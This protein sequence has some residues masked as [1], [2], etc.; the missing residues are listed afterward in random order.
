MNYNEKSKEYFQQLFEGLSARAQAIL[1]Y[2]EMN[3]IESISPWLIGEADERECIRSCGEQTSQEF[4]IMVHQLKI[5][6]ANESDGTDAGKAIGEPVSSRIQTSNDVFRSKEAQMEFERLQDNLSLRAKNILVS[7]GGIEDIVPWIEGKY[8]DFLNCRNCGRKTSDELMEMM[9]KLRER[10]F[11]LEHES[12]SEK[13]QKRIE[14]LKENFKTKYEQ[15]VDPS[16]MD[17]LASKYMQL[18]YFPF[19]LALNS[20]KFSYENGDS[21]VLRLCSNIFDEKKKISYSDIAL[22]FAI[23]PE[24]VRR[25]RDSQF[26]ELQNIIMDLFRTGCLGDYK[27][28]IETADELKRIVSREGVP[29]NGNFIVWVVCQIDERY[30]LIGDVNNA[31][32]G[33][34][35]S[36]ETLSAVR[37]ELCDFFDFRN[38][39]E[40]VETRLQEN[41]FD[42]E[43]IELEQYVSH[44]YTGCTDNPIFDTIVKACRNILEMRRP[45]IMVNNQIVFP[46]NTMKP[47]SLLV[48]DLL[49]EFNRPM[50]VDEICKQLSTRFP[51]IK[52]TPSRIRNTLRQK[53]FVPVSRTSTYALAEWS[54]TDKCGGTIREMVAEYL[55]SLSQPIA[56]LDE[57]C[58]YLAKHRKGISM[59]SVKTNLLAEAKKRF[60]LY[61][62]DGIQYIGLSDGECNLTKSPIA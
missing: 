47:I 32:F 25:M 24:R 43:R 29:F 6:L 22:R 10:L 56:S 62:K 54:H 12:E 5:Y 8:N 28:N 33:A 14:R 3:S 57:I 48:E 49:R 9:V 60:C 34:T 1:K 38:F 17:L 13:Q 7:L 2:N 46:K 20:G 23:T 59:K 41:R 52:I 53:N 30:R 37:D 40:S 39:V 58:E 26:Q 36:K 55:N 50:H 45:E 21:F 35:T 44:M 19:F 16:K 4:M 27:Y 61:R 31:F 11:L 51:D 42:D 15:F 18:G